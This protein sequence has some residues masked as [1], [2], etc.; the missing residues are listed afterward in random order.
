MCRSHGTRQHPL[1]S[2]DLDDFTR[3]RRKSAGPIRRKVFLIPTPQRLGAS[4]RIAIIGAGATGTYC[5]DA[6]LAKKVASEVVV[7]EASDRLGPGLAYSSNLN[8]V[9]ALSNI[10]GIEVPPLCET[11]NAWAVRQ[12]RARLNDWGIAHL[13]GDDRAFFPRVVLGAWLDDQFGQLCASSKVPVTV[14]SLT[15]VLDVVALP[16][17]C[18]LDWRG[19]DGARAQDTFDRV[20]IASGYGAIGMDD[21]PSEL[22]TGKS[23]ATVASTS[24]TARFGVLGSSLS[25]IDAVVAIAMARGSFVE[26][27]NS[28]RYVAHTPWQ[29][30]MMSRNGLLPEADFWFPHPL[31]ELGTFTTETAA[32]CMR[33]DDGDLDR[34]FE[35]FAVV[36]AEQAPDW[37][38]AIGLR[39]ATADDFAERY[40]AHRRSG[41]VWEHARENLAHVKEWSHNHQTP[42]WR[43]IILKAH[44]IFAS[45]VSSLTRRDLSRLHRGLKRVFTDNYAAVPHLSI[46]R[47]L[48]LHE[49]GV[50]DVIALGNDYEIQPANSAWLVHSHKWSGRFDELIDARGP[51]AAALTHFPFPTVRLQLCAS[52]LEESQDWHD[53]INPATDLT[54]SEHDP[55][56]RRVHLCALPFLLRN[57]PFVQGL[58]E[59]AA[60]ARAVSEAIHEAQNAIS[61]DY[62]SAEFLME[63]LD[64][65]A[66][67]LGNGEVLPLAG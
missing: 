46:E 31:P 48:A 42:A 29:A 51:Q 64:R 37:S 54:V 30:V 12:P 35:K 62:S 45:A 57:R 49:A 5:L 33:G 67:I 50:L 38:A 8:D 59:C 19:P 40:F 16:D 52:V 27:A 13:A 39:D 28:L 56:L 65:P 61:T 1:R 24:T 18:R 2:I 36:L 63:L 10:A 53:G 43:I 21:N 26:E 7:F 3:Q 15:E 55:S 32:A 44:E 6:L 66:I 14:H 22:R 9:H 23:A 47:V 34:L 20:I 17:G 41:N 4:E 11:L 58:V 60:L 25:G